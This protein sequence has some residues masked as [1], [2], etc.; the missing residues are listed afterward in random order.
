LT[1]NEKEIVDLHNGTVNHR[2]IHWRWTDKGN[3]GK[4]RVTTYL[5]DNYPGEVVIFD[6]GEYGDLCY[7]ITE[8]DMRYVKTII[9]DMPRGCGGHISFMMLEALSNMRIRSTKYKGGFKRF[10]PCNL[11]VVSNSPPASL[12]DLS[13][14]RW[15]IIEWTDAPLAGAPEVPLT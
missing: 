9:W 11:I 15:D 8:A 5:Y 4:S 6:K 14:D 13:G 10:P 7:A 12:H 1:A 2:K 3:V